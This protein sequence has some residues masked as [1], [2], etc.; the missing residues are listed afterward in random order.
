MEYV[1]EEGITFSDGGGVLEFWVLF[2]W[3]DNNE[4]KILIANRERRYRG[5]ETT[6]E[7]T[8]N[9]GRSVPSLDTG[10]WG[11]LGLKSTFFFGQRQRQDEP[12]QLKLSSPKS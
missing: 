1:T 7:E 11:R 5:G 3:G 2:G 8:T 12:S 6:R 4:A 10:Y 9:W